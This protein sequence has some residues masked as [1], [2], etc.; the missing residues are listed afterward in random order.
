M[1]AQ[2]EVHACLDVN[3]VNGTC[4]RNNLLVKLQTRLSS[5]NLG[6]EPLFTIET[7][8][9]NNDRIRIIGVEAGSPA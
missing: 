6:S 9:P 2:P 7:E 5:L 8:A 1:S 4:E 3:Q